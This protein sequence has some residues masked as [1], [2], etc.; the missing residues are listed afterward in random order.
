MHLREPTQGAGA[1]WVRRGTDYQ[2]I[3]RTT[4][5]EKKTKQPCRL[6]LSMKLG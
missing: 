6:T 1:H 5:E 3:Q 4:Q 2:I